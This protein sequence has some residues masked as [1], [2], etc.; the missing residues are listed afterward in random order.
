MCDQN[1]NCPFPTEQEEEEAKVNDLLNEL[2]HLEHWFWFGTNLGVSQ[3]RLL[4]IKAES[5]D[6]PIRIQKTIVEWGR[7]EV[8]KW[9]KVIQA[10][11]KMGERHKA[12][13]LS[14]KYGQFCQDMYEQ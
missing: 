5:G 7:L 9:S 8:R 10:L 13:M 4:Q 12:E 2:C 14:T 6:I 1:I 3:D 11:S